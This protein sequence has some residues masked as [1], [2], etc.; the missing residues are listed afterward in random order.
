MHETNNMPLGLVPSFYHEFCRNT[1]GPKSLDGPTHYTA[2][3]TSSPSNIPPAEHAGYVFRN[4]YKNSL[5][6]LAGENGEEVWCLFLDTIWGRP[7]PPPLPCYWIPRLMASTGSTSVDANCISMPLGLCVFLT[8][9]IMNW[10]I[11]LKAAGMRN[12]LWYGA[13]FSTG[14]YTRGC[15]WFPR[16]LA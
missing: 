13:G 8:V 5:W 16:L 10:V 12:D 15:H 2:K 7:P 6:F 1:E 14:I 4:L 3:G 9:P 11:T